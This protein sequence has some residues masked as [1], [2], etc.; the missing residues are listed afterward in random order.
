MLRRTQLSAR[1]LP[2]LA[3]FFVLMLAAAG[4]GHSGY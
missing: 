2:L 4:C 3:L 1:W